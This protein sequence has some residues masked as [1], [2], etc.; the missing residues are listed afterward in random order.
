VYCAQTEVV[1]GKKTGTLE[2]LPQIVESLIHAVS[3]QIVD[4]SVTGHL[5][6]RIVRPNDALAQV[7]LTGVEIGN[8]GAHMEKDINVI[9]DVDPDEAQLLIGLIEYLV[10]AWYVERYEKEQHLAEILKVQ[11]EKAAAKKAATTPA[12]TTPATPTVTKP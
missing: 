8:I 5:A 10:K 9:V 12:A 2:F 11:A 7:T 1:A 3:P 6:A 4:P